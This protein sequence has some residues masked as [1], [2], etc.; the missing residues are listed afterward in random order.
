M[1]SIYNILLK[2]HNS[3]KEKDS[4][5]EIGVESYIIFKVIDEIKI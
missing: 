5:K 4:L 3:I 2:E 1:S